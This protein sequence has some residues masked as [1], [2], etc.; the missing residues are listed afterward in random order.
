MFVRQKNV[1]KKKK[2]AEGNG[3][4]NFLSPTLF[5]AILFKASVATVSEGATFIKQIEPMT[6]QT[7][8]SCL[9]GY[10]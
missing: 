4:S 9:K 2:Q 1:A 5:V 10:M 7:T 8:A 6:E 3:S